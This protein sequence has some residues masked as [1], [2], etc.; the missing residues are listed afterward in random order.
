M[1]EVNKRKIRL[2]KIYDYLKLCSDENS[3]LTTEDLA[4][5]LAEEGIE[6]DRRTLYKDIE[7]LNEFG[8]E[9]ESVRCKHKMGY[10]I[11]ERL[12]DVSELR[13]LI[14]AVNAAGFITKTKSKT[15]TEKLASLAGSVHAEELKKHTKTSASKHT[16]ESVYYNVNALSEAIRKDKKASFLYFDLDSKGKKVYRK[17]E[18]YLVEP[19]ALVFSND[20]YYLAAYN[21]KYDTI[22]NYRVDR[23]DGANTEK[24]PIC[25][26]AKRRKEKGLSDGKLFGMYNGPVEKITLEFD[27]SLCNA[28]YDRFGEDIQ[29][30]H[31][32]DMASVT[33]EIA[34]SPAFY[35][36]I[37]TYGGDIKIKKPQ[38]A[39]DAYRE[40]AKK[41]LD[42]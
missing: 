31:Y 5:K 38:S 30:V 32:G 6:C 23:M 3:P 24:E 11:P 21:A 2:L 34:V 20:N 18:P 16:N 12:F 8:Y 33:A 27:E 26:E 17:K 39:V 25:E 9:V 13:I 29:V 10:Y 37:F 40:F 36:W 1:A 42:I 41:A 19:L 28:V 14:D 22:N 15:F 35:G 4:A 7:V